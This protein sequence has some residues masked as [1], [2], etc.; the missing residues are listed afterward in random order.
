MSPTDTPGPE[1]ASDEE[2]VEFLRWLAENL[3]TIKAMKAESFDDPKFKELVGPTTFSNRLPNIAR[4]FISDV[5]K[6]PGPKGLRLEGGDGGGRSR[7]GTETR[8]V[9][10]A[11][12]PAMQAGG[13]KPAAR[14][15][16]KP[17]RKKK[18]R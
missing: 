2:V 14:A 7:R 10:R 18:P 13:S 5:M 11:K 16:R 8:Q 3:P 17:Q 4:R 6:R 1:P 9:G 15:Q 12:P